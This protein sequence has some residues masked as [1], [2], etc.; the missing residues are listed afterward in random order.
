MKNP[1]LS[2][3]SSTTN[4]FCYFSD[5]PG[6]GSRG[7]AEEERGTQIEGGADGRPPREAQE[8]VCREGGQPFKP[9]D[10]R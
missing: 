8:Q 3:D 6:R 2:Y 7:A 10:I 9:Q 1:R 4:Q 5:R